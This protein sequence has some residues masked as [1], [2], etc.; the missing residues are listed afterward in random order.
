MFIIADYSSQEVRILADKTQDPTLLDALRS[1]KDLHRITAAA[2]F[3]KPEDQITPEER[4]MAKIN[5]FM[6]IYGGGVDKMMEQ[7]GLTKQQATKMLSNLFSRYPGIKEYQDRVSDF[8][9]EHGYM[10]T[11]DY[12]Y[13]KIYVE[14]YELLR[15]LEPRKRRQAIGK[16]FRD[17]SNYNIQSTAA[18][19]TKL[20]GIYLRDA[21]VKLVLCIHDE[22]VVEC[23]AEDAERVKLI[24]EDCMSRAAKALCKSIDIPAEAKIVNQ[25]TK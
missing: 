1:G 18:T 13:R 7:F 2:L 16:I 12:I 17:S 9:L 21:G 23:K 3:E 19:M 20:A 5:L 6:S 4:K 25:W 11:D 10:V 8:S 24:V 22:V 14:G 15:F